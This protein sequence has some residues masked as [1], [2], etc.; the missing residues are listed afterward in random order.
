MD[1]GVRKR[2]SYF[3]YISQKVGRVSQTTGTPV[4]LKTRRQNV[5]EYS[6]IKIYESSNT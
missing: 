1:R 3:V 4:V 2:H 6:Q 5:V